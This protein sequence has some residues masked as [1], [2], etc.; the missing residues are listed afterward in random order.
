GA[1]DGE[2]PGRLAGGQAPLRP[3]RADLGGARG[4][5]ALEPRLGGAGA[6]PRRRERPYPAREL[7]A[8]VRE[9]ALGGAQPLDQAAVPARG[10]DEPVDARRRVVERGGAEQDRD[11]AG[12]ALLVEQ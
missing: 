2:Q 9:T 7:D 6:E 5:G 1:G 4:A 3:Q 11:R 8:R 10:A 12:L